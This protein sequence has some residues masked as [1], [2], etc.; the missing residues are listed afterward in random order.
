LAYGPLKLA[1][2]EWIESVH[3]LFDFTVDVGPARSFQPV[4]KSVS[5]MVPKSDVIVL[6]VSRAAVLTVAETVVPTV[7]LV[8]VLS[9]VHV[10]ALSP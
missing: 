9:I 6:S 7:Q 3:A 5:R 1:A 2:V 10:W 8:G 4:L